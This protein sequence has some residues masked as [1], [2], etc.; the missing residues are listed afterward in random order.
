MLNADG[1]AAAME[2]AAD[3]Q[4]AAQIAT[5]DALGTGGFDGGQLAIEHAAGDVGVLDREQAAEAAAL[6]LLVHGRLLHAVDGGEHRERLVTDAE[7]A[8]R[9]TRGMERD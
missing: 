6:F 7:A 5:D 9:V 8:Q 3:V 4:E 2:A 1:G